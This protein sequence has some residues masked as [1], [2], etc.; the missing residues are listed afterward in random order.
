VSEV[1]VGGGDRSGVLRGERARIRS[2]WMRIKV[3]MIRHT[4]A[5]W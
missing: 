2:G 5:N 1:A 3:V 4:T